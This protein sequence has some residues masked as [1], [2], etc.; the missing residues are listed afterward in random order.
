MN[1]QRIKCILLGLCFT[2]VALSPLRCSRWE[3]TRW[4][5]D[6]GDMAEVIMP[7]LTTAVILLRD[8]WAIFPHWL[9]ACAATTLSVSLLKH[10]IPARRPGGG[11]HSFP[12]GHTATA[13]LSAC[14]LLLRYG[15]RWGLLLLWA[16][17]VGFSRIYSHSHYLRDVL[18]GAL[19]G[20]ACACLSGFIWRKLLRC[21]ATHQK[22]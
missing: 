6:T 4:I 15:S 3:S 17:F 2:A 13:F 20:S 10:A 22:D 19:I 5:R 14:F 21:F 12:S 7:C 1:H 18:A 11:Q 8:D 9:V 16:G